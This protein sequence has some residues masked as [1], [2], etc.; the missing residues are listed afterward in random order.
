MKPR[1]RLLTGTAALLLS[2]CAGLGLIGMADARSEEPT[3]GSITPML[4]YRAGGR[5]D[6]PLS[7]SRLR[8]DDDA[9][10]AV[11][12]NLVQAPGRLY[13]LYYGR[14][15]SGLQGSELQLQ[16]EYLHVGGMLTWPRPGYEGFVTGTLG[17]TRFRPGRSTGDS[18]I[19]PSASLGLGV[20]LPLT[21]RL[22]VRLEARG[23]ITLTDGER[24]LLCVSGPEGGACALSYEGDSF[25]QYE[26]LAGLALRF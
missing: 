15:R 2:W 10:L 24:G 5:F 6:S 12:A 21:R 25:I 3:M 11:A 8:V 1:Y 9:T 20:H 4:G 18:D 26:A 17:A 13:E 22:A 19:R 7:D 23:F 14:Q 16:V